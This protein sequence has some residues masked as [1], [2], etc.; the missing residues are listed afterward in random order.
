MVDVS[1][2][3]VTSG[4]RTAE[5]FVAMAPETLGLILRGGA[6]RRATCSPPP[7]SPAS[8]RRSGRMS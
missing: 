3:A 5:G 2:K 7:A 1:D 6:P 4:A 8:W